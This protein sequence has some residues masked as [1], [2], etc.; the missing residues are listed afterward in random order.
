MSCK[1]QTLPMRTVYLAG[2]ITGNSYEEA[3]NGWRS[4]IVDMFPA[5]I[6]CL[7]PMRGT[8][9]L[10]SVKNMQATP[11]AYDYDPISSASGILDRDYNDVLMSDAVI[12]NLLD[13]DRVSIGTC[14]EFGWAHAY[15]KPVVMVCEESD[16]HWHTML[17]EIAT[18]VVPDLEQASHLTTHLLTPGV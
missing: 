5:H 10:H 2:P 11:G 3:R 17:I 13:T 9:S 1:R 12:V 7:S 8:D 14:V 6:H 15:R 16:I 18:Y 4:K